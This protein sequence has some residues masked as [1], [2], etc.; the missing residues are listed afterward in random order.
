MRLPS[1]VPSRALTVTI[2]GD[3]HLD[4]TW[5]SEPCFGTYLNRFKL[6]QRPDGTVYGRALDSLDGLTD[7]EAVARLREVWDAIFDAHFVRGT[8]R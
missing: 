3:G 4:M 2:T 5:V 6:N 8:C 7:E 1:N